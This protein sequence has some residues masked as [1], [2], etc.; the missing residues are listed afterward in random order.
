METWVEFTSCA[1]LP[2]YISVEDCRHVLTNL[3]VG[4]I[5]VILQKEK[6]I[7]GKT[8]LKKPSLLTSR[9][10]RRPCPW[11]TWP[12]WRR[13]RA[14]SSDQCV[15]RHLTSCSRGQYYQEPGRRISEIRVG[16]IIKVFDNFYGVYLVYNNQGDQIGQ[17]L[18]VLGNIFSYKNGP[19]IW[20]LLGLFLPYIFQ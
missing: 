11:W 20:R 5:G 4:S 7:Y 18:K 19:N 10:R 2:R 12:W 9:S 6:V 1:N 8:F 3:T 15:Q 17:V 14:S 13:R 16:K